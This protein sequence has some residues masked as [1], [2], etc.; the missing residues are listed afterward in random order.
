MSKLSGRFT[1]LT[2]L[3]H[4]RLRTKFLLSTCLLLSF[5]ILAL[6][7]IV[8]KEQ[9]ES[10]RAQ[11]E[12]RGYMMANNLAAVSTKSLL[13]YNYVALEQDAERLARDEDV[14]YVI[15]LTKEGKVAAYSGRDEKQGEIL[16]DPVSQK[17]MATQS[18][19]VQ[20]IVDP[21]TKETGLDFTVPVF[22]AP[23][24]ERWGVVRVGLSLH[25]MYEEIRETR[26]YIIEVGG[27]VLL[28]GIVAAIFMAQRIASPIGKLVE[29]AIEVS[30]GNLH[31]WIE[32]E[33]G[34]E[35]GNLAR[36][37]NQMTVQL[38]YQR[39]ELEQKNQEL[40]QRL[41]EISL[42]KNYNDNI[43]HSMTGGVITLDLSGRVIMLNEAA[44]RLLGFSLEQV[45]GKLIVDLFTPDQEFPTLLL[46]TLETGGVFHQQCVIERD[47]EYSV[48]ISITTSLLTDS[49]EN[50]TGV[51]GVFQDLSPIR[52][53][54]QQLRRADR[55]AALGT[56]AA[57]VAH[58]IKNP[59]VALKT[60][61]E[62]LPRKKDNP[63]FFEKYM[64]IVPHELDRVNYIV[65]ELLTLARPSKMLF[66]PANINS[67]LGES[68]ELH[69]EQAAELGVIIHEQYAPDLPPVS[70]DPDHLKRVFGNCISNALQAMPTGGDLTITSGLIHLENSELPSSR[71]AYQH[72]R[73]KSY[74]KP[75]F[76]PFVALRF[77]DTGT[78]MSAE[79]LNSLFTPFFTTKGKGTGL[80]LAISHK[81]VEEHGG[82]MQVE[83]QLG[84]G[85]TLTI[86]LPLIPQL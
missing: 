38:L 70:V 44:E 74:T 35:I 29:G 63:E 56:L 58:E 86:L 54:E 32:I 15:I 81:I 80:G 71:H 22:I 48:P 72:S 60:F 45:Q 3:A 21:M 36:Q 19:M 2:L 33:S 83:S 4:L 16:N 17:A 41:R 8:E 69:K 30:K 68:V 39:R 1:F 23:Y 42:L 11:V 49:E 51:L 73:P 27:V 47:K 78:G 5:L 59:L 64:R 79:Q 85:T 31:H 57:G 62:V 43:L 13:T 24:N 50:V 26:L 77:T 10:I 14:L 55:L 46:Q 25:A 67:I 37:F 6:L 84:V 20:T 40:N 75:A 52:E 76:N 28:L 65:E 18:P 82:F 7:L 61:T 53:L 66:R 9:R 12:K 34:D